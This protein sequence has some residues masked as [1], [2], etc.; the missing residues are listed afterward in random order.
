MKII[1]LILEKNIGMNLNAVFERKL[2]S[3]TAGDIYKIGHDSIRLLK[4]LAKFDRSFY[5]NINYYVWMANKII[6]LKND[7]HIKHFNNNIDT[8]NETWYF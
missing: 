3:R 2:Y 6:S 7:I 4:W 8:Q 1:K 5:E